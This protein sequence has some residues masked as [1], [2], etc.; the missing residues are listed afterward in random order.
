MARNSGP[1]TKP[2]TKTVGRSGKTTPAVAEDD[3]ALWEK[4]TETVKPLKSNR[5]TKTAPVEQK[6]GI[7]TPEKRVRQYKTSSPPPH[8]APSSRKQ[9]E[10]LS[11]GTAAG[12]DKRTN[13]RL[14]RGKFPIEG[15]LDLHGDTKKTAHRSLE[16]FIK[17]AFSA[18]KRCVIVITGKGLRVDSGEIGVLRQAVPQW[19]NSPALRPMVLAY[20]H[21]TPKDGGEG[22]LYVLL[23]RKR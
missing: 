10:E 13:Q 8:H 12:V 17:G 1:G 14:V 23:K 6:S 15:R 16:A 19:L 5:I 2:G 7:E 11:H 3:A 22:A 20:S 4:V 21:A 18:E 9:L